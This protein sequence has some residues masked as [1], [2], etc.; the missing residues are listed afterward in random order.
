MQPKSIKNSPTVSFTYSYLGSVWKKFLNGSFKKCS[1]SEV[2][3]FLQFCTQIPRASSL[4]IFF[5]QNQNLKQQ[6]EKSKIECHKETDPSF[7]FTEYQLII[8]FIYSFNQHVYSAT[9]LHRDETSD[10]QEASN[11]CNKI[12]H[13]IGNK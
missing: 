13:M 4:E 11:R 8:W 1:L 6:K 2:Y 7:P 12:K 9:H 3:H 5:S 10:S